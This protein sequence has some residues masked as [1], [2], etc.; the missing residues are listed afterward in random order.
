M[1]RAGPCAGCAHRGTGWAWRETETDVS[2]SCGFGRPGIISSRRLFSPLGK[3]CRKGYT[4]L[5][6]VRRGES[7]A[8]LAAK[9][10]EQ[11][12]QQQLQQ[13]QVPLRQFD[14]CGCYATKMMAMAT[15]IPTYDC[16]CG[17]VAESADG[18]ARIPPPPPPPPLLLPVPG[19]TATTCDV[20]GRAD[21]SRCRCVWK[22]S[23]P[24][25]PLPVVAGTGSR[26]T[27]AAAA[28]TTGSRRCVASPR[29]SDVVAAAATASCDVR[30]VTATSS[31]INGRGGMTSALGGDVVCTSSY[32]AAPPRDDATNSSRRV[33]A[34]ESAASVTDVRLTD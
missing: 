16:P 23:S 33:A 7:G 10:F 28:L 20:C 24:Y 19:A 6:C 9:R 30:R 4:F 2:C 8:S 11:Q 21:E 27:S 17:A 13:Q 14:D 31:P 25:S 3:S 34:S 12:R 22:P 32:T 15:T 26:A 5:V 1:E 29:P 18:V